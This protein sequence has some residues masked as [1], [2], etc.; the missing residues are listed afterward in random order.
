MHQVVVA[1]MLALVGDALYV[2]VAENWACEVA[3]AGLMLT[4]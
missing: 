4:D 1:V 2:P 3:A